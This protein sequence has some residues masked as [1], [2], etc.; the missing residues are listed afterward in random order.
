MSRKSNPFDILKSL[1]G[2]NDTNAGNSFFDNFLNNEHIK[3]LTKDGSMNTVIDLIS[4]MA[5]NLINPDVFIQILDANPN[6]NDEF[7]TEQINSFKKSHPQSN[8]IINQ[9][10]Q[11]Y[12]EKQSD[13]NIYNIRKFV[14]SDDCK[15]ALNDPQVKQYLK[16]LMNSPEFRQKI[17]IFNLKK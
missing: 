12:E 17:N 13:K 1:T 11:P 14:K 4:K 9:Y 8:D 6:L 2:G 5:P 10:L 15:R 3:E 7:L 16:E